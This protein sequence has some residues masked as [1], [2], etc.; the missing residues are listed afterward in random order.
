MKN[1]KLSESFKCAFTGILGTLAKERNFKIHVCAAVCI[2]GL[3]IFLKVSVIEF[4]CVLV[5]IS[6][7]LAAELLNTAIE[8]AI[9]L[10][11]GDKFHPL[12]KAAK[13][14]AAGAVL[15][16]AINAVAVGAAIFFKKLIDLFI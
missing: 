5:T 1:K 2:L 14:A 7:V 8:A 4:I 11:T 6:M 13:D 16:T 12:A 3:A 9:D 15:I 10:F